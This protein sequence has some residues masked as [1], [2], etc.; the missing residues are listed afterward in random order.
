MEC[1]EFLTDYS[2]FLDCRFEQHSKVGYCD[3][4]LRCADCAE[5]D[6]VV[7]R[8]LELLRGLEAPEARAGL[9]PRVSERVLGCGPGLSAGAD[10]GRAVLVAGVAAVALFVGGSLAVLDS[11]STAQLPPVVVEAVAADEVPSL[12]GPAPTFTP[13]VSLM[14]APDLSGGRP[15]RLPPQGLSLFRAPLSTSRRTPAAD[16]TA[17]P[18]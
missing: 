14:R 15:L 10:R 13:A 8:G 5:Y 11:G 3:H 9:L 12:W 2:D 1:E 18:E 4:L 7:R 16:L 17:A 6:R